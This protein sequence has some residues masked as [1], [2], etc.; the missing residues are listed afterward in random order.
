M[1]VSYEEA[2]EFEM[3][4]ETAVTTT[5]SILDQLVVMAAAGN[6]AVS[7]RAR[8]LNLVARRARLLVSLIGA[9]P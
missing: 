1:S 7:A 5:M 9:N 4:V 3:A 6:P 8:D 2:V